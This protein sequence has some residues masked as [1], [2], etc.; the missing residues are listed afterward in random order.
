[1]SNKR[2]KKNKKKKEKKEIIFRT[3]EERQQEVYTIIK[4]LSEFDLNMLYEPVKKLY[5]IFKKYIQEGSRE[6]VNIPFPEINRRIKG[7]LAIS[8]K[9][10]VWISLKNEKF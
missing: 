1:M 8:V 9:E 10:E 4:Q 3:K 7:V 5:E 2:N 6:E